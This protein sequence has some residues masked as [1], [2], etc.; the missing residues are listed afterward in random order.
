M[1][2]MIMV[3]M[4]IMALLIPGVLS[5][6]TTSGRPTTADAKSNHSMFEGDALHVHEP[7]RLELRFRMVLRLPLA[8]PAISNIVT[9]SAIA[10]PSSETFEIICVLIIFSRVLI[11]ATFRTGPTWVRAGYMESG[12]LASDRIFP[13]IFDWS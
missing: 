10:L 1:L 9:S 3:I 2:V 11:V 4:M 12:K 6:M 7:G 13:Q 8:G 5:M